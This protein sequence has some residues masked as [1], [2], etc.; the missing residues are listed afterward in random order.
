[1]LRLTALFLAAFVAVSAQAAPAVGQGAPD[2]T[3]KDA[4]ARPS[5]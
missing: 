2:F 1:M 3:L 4:A 5:S